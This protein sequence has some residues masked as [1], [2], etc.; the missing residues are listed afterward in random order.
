[1]TT[2]VP[3]FKDLFSVYPPNDPRWQVYEQKAF[4]VCVRYTNNTGAPRPMWEIR[5]G[6]DGKTELKDG[7]PKELAPGETRWIAI[8][9]SNKTFFYKSHEN[10]GGANWGGAAYPKTDEDA[11]AQWKPLKACDIKGIYATLRKKRLVVPFFQIADALKTLH[12][13][14]VSP[15]AL[16]DRLKA[17]VSH[18]GYPGKVAIMKSR[19]VVAGMS[20][21]GRKLIQLQPVFPMGYR[22]VP[23][24]KGC[25]LIVDLEGKGLK[26]GKIKYMGMDMDEN[27]QV[28]LEGVMAR[29]IDAP[30]VKG[31]VW[32]KTDTQ[33]ALDKVLK[34]AETLLV[35]EEMYKTV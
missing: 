21:S 5:S 7:K 6:K 27:K 28:Q 29:I 3:F 30:Q 8:E 17:G 11:R 9:P 19:A 12:G 24:E 35:A 33:W 31:A 34:K 18:L 22:P 13:I 14:Q 4:K 10:Q 23:I 25:L 15:E 32:M 20:V 16:E 26:K 2:P 1:M